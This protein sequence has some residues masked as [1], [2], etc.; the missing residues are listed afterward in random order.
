[1]ER[2]EIR[3]E[4]GVGVTRFPHEGSKGMWIY[5]AREWKG[6]FEARLVRGC[7]GGVLQGE[8]G[9]HSMHRVDVI[10]GKGGR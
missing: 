7:G 8:W 5:R 10:G 9:V 6:G 4:F 3:G 2:W 1:M